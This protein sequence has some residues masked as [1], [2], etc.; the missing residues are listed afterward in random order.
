MTKP[1]AQATRARQRRPFF[2]K[3]FRLPS[4]S[5]L[6]QF[7]FAPFAYRLAGIAL[8]AILVAP[9]FQADDANTPEGIKE[10]AGF[11]DSLPEELAV[12][13]ELQTRARTEVEVL[14]DETL[15]E[16]LHNSDGQPDDNSSTDP[17]TQVASAAST[18]SPPEQEKPA[19]LD[20]P[21]VSKAQPIPANTVK[22]GQRTRKLALT[23]PASREVELTPADIEP[24]RVKIK[25]GDNM[26][27][28]FQRAGLGPGLVHQLA[29]ES[30][31]G[32]SFSKIFPGKYFD[33]Y[34]DADKKLNRVVYQLSRLESYEASHNGSGFDTRHVEL[35]PEVFTTIKTGVI[36]SSFYL[37]GLEA[38]LNDNLIMEL[39]GIFGWDIDF[40]LE[41]RTGDSFSVLFEELYLD[42]E[43]LG[44]GNILAAE[45]VNR[46]K[47][48]RGIRYEDQNGK[49][50][51]YDPQGR[52]MKKAFL[53]TPLDVFRISSHFNLKRKHPVL[54]RI[55]AH[56]GTDYAAS[57]GTPI[58][59][60]GA[61]KVIYAATQGGYG[62]V[63]KIQHG[64]TY[65]TVYAH[66]DRYAR[67]IR[68]G[69][70]VRQGQIIGYVGSTGLATGPHLHYEFYVNGSVRNPLTV[71]LPNGD[72]INKKELGRFQQLS[73]QYLP[74]LD[75][76]GG[77]YAQSPPNPVRGDANG[78]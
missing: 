39:S 3:R 44:T 58:R 24:V 52:S 48:V 61:G 53:R 35:Q 33:F 68:R 19:Q 7:M 36:D 50:A 6:P 56:K 15:T 65:K 23:I 2:L 30:E 26:S 67:G 8:V 4:L 57:R 60:S 49:V 59:A 11:E 54:N 12:V 69:T 1:K 47:S 14:A 42:G 66:M 21:S 72:P 17:I 76:P 9:L 55:R 28:L 70:T 43:Y 10:V 32:K 16:N 13:F 5:I 18:D 22:N 29:Y 34:F 25:S 40:A 77:S 45:F 37:D 20:S 27:L 78:S 41:I 74:M 75:I 64:Q 62:K 73:R 31:H 46:G 63:V 71:K 38:G 51:F